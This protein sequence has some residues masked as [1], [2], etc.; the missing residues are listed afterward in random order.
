[1]TRYLLIFVIVV[2][3]SGC[4]F[5]PD[6]KVSDIIEGQDNILPN[7]MVVSD[8][9]QAS[10]IGAE[11]LR[12]G[13]NAIDA[14]VATELALAVCYPEAGNIG[15]GGFMVIRTK[16]GS[17]DAIDFR[18]KAP[19]KAS[20]DMYL[21]KAG[22]VKEGLSTNTQLASGVPG[23]IDGLLKAHAK[24]GKLAFKDIIQ[25]AIDLAVNGFPLSPAQTNSLNSNRN[26][27]VERN[28]HKTAFVRDSLWKTGEILK[29]PELAETLIR[30]RDSGRN[31]FYSGKTAELIIR[32]MKRGNG[33][34]TAKDLEDYN[35]VWRQPLTGEYKGYKIITMSPPSGGGITLLQLLKMTEKYPLKDMGFH[36][37]QSIHLIT[38]AERRAFADRAEFSGDPDFV[39]VPV[40]KLIAAQYLK[41]RMKSFDSER[42][43][44][45]S[46]IGHGSP[47]PYESEQTTHYSVVDS[48]GNAVSTTTT[49]NNTF[50]N[51]IV[52]EG[53]G[54]LLNNEMDDF[55]SKPGFP[56]MYGLVEGEANSVQ[57]G[58]RM[59]SSMT[60]TIIEKDGKLFLVLG[61][62][63]GGRIPTTIFQVIINVLD[64]GMNIQEAVN[65]GRFHHQWLP[66]HIDYEKSSIDSITLKKLESMGHSLKVRNSI[67]LVN[68]IQNLPDGRKAGGADHRGYNVASG[69]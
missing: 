35:S 49:L 48:I 58:K 47:L 65:A 16:D 9:P 13:G 6:K 34:I 29:Q 53:A 68:A 43:S 61:S 54:F 11:I 45:S 52:V 18:E 8:H 10:V 17:V 55:S 37:V 23:T 56:N 64:F 30:I 4:G 62:P 44:L 26:T 40:R 57:A 39:Q 2:I 19:G 5:R 51:S 24:Y 27:F 38:E 12:K 7:G 63:G 67:G 31:G 22:I 25:P 3:Q 33:I 41:D 15:G 36:T 20:R 50:G 14:A 60:P 46:V 59:L 69:F 28:H 21:D 66:D 32:E 42:A 1:M